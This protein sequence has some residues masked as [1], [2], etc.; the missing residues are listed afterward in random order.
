MFQPVFGAWGTTIF[1]LSL[2]VG[3]FG[4]AVEIALNAAY[5]LAQSFGWPWGV[6]KPRRQAARFTVV[7]SLM[8]VLAAIVGVLG[9]D[10][11]QLTQIALA[12]TVVLMPVVVLPFLVLMNNPGFVKRHTSGTIGNAA[13][14]VLTIA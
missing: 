3:C 11:L 4:A 12:L 8:L 13:L 2:G 10:P 9:F 5:A 7:F 6:E 1:A 14:A